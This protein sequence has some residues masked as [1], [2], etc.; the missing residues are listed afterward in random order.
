MAEPFDHA[1]L[2]TYCVTQRR[3]S[4]SAPARTRNARSS[5]GVVV[6]G[7]NVF[8][9]SFRGQAQNGYASAVR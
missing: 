5:S 3:R 7:D 2:G 6:V 1:T 8:A 9:R 4:R